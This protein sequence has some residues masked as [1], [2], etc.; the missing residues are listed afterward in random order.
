MQKLTFEAII[1]IHDNVI[2]PNE[3]QGQ[4]P[5]KSIEAI[6]GRVI[7]RINYALINDIFDLSACYASY[8]AQGHV[9]NDANKRTVFASMDTVLA[10]NGILLEYDTEEAGNMIIKIVLNQIDEKYIAEWLRKLNNQI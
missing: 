3:L 4:A 5:H 2:K 10:I 8:I 1:L 9:F 7:N 6:T